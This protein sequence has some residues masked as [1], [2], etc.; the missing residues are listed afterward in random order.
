M[1]SFVWKASE[2]A[3]TK[4][5]QLSSIVLKN[6]DIRAQTSTSHTLPKLDGENI[7]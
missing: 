3:D 4:K 1:Q 2:N 6:F 5:F 7:L